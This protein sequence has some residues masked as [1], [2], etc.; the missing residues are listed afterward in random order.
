MRYA[1]VQKELLVPDAELLARAFCTLPELTQID[2][3]NAANDAFGILLRGL[4]VERAGA[5]QAALAHEGIETEAVREDELPSLPSARIVR[6]VEVTAEHLVVMD[7]MRR[8]TRIPWGDLLLIAAGQVRTREMR[9]LRTALD[10]PGF[11]GAG[12]SQDAVTP[13]RIRDEEHERLV[14]DLFLSDRAARFS[15]S[16]DEFDFQHL[17][18]RL[19]EDPAINF[20][21]ILQDLD[22]Y[23]PHAS[24]NQGAFLAC[25]KPPQLFRYPSKQAYQEELIWMLWRIGRLVSSVKT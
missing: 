12:V 25:Q 13:S 10:E 14:V 24:L 4:D 8:E 9:R 3:R 6:Q 19:S 15:L 11:H 18:P 5:L 17:G 21:S 20:L 22:Q 7:P 23:A 16:A 1:I 2:A